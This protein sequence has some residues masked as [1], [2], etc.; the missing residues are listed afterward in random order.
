LGQVFR[1]EPR[2]G[3]TLR[4]DIHR[5]DTLRKPIF[6]PPNWVFPIAWPINN[7]GAID[8]ARRV[9]NKPSGTAGRATYLTLQGATWLD[10]VLFSAA[11]FGLR[12]PISSLILTGVYLLLTVASLFVALFRLKDT[13][14]ALSLATTFVWLLI[15][16]PSAAAQAARNRDPFWGAGPFA[17]PDRALLKRTAWRER[18]GEGRTEYHTLYRLRRRH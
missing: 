15:A 5:S 10:H 2:R 6:Q 17:T 9:L 4:G 8:G 7:I 16:L 11:Y 1:G 14:V 13:R 12:S 3:R 18:T